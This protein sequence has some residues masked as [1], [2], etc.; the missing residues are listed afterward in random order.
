[1]LCNIISV[2]TNTTHVMQYYLRGDEHN[3]TWTQ[4]SKVT[5]AKG[6]LNLEHQM[7]NYLNAKLAPG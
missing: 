6:Y 7:L 5:P 3:Q 2:A 1:M 4:S